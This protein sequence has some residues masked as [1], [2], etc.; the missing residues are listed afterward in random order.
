MAPWFFY[1]AGWHLVLRVVGQVNVMRCGLD[2]Y[3]YLGKG[4]CLLSDNPFRQR[5]R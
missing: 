5:S 4:Y 1:E 2:W 3:Q